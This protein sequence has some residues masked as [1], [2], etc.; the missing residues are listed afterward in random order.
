PFHD[1]SVSREILPILIGCV[2]NNFSR[3]IMHQFFHHEQVKKLVYIDAGNESVV[4]PKDYPSRPR[5]DWSEEELESYN[6][7]GWSG[8]VVCGYKQFG[9]IKLNPV[10]DVY[11]DILDDT[12]DIAP[13]QLSCEE[14][15]SSDPQRST[16]NRFAA[17]AVSSMVADILETKSITN[18]KTVFHARKGYM[19]SEPASLES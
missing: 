10:A 8:Q 2:D 17:M 4:I 13:S 16:T 14:V 6:A 18:H 7:S 12:D 11:P 3:Q 1:S 5:K 15:S 9:H 19:K